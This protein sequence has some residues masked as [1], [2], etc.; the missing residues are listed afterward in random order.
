MSK[1]VLLLEATGN[2]V[3][4]RFD[5]ANWVT[6][7]NPEEMRTVE[8]ENAEAAMRVFEHELGI[9]VRY[10]RGAG[11]TDNNLH[12]YSAESL[13]DVVAL[14]KKPVDATWKIELNCHC[15]GCGKYV[16]VAADRGFWIGSD[17]SPGEQGTPSSSDQDVTCPKC[18][19]EF[20]VCCEGVE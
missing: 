15:P 10:R 16:D 13:D 12:R 19:H 9:D 17:L 1:F 8:A 3:S 11:V 2:Y 7:S 14:F 5:I 6:S 18:R 4:T 20:K